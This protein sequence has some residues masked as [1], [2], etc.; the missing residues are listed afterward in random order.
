LTENPPKPTDLIY[1]NSF[2]HFQF[3]GCEV[4]VVFYD[5]YRLSVGYSQNDVKSPI[6]ETRF[7]L[8]VQTKT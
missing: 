4:S 1:F 6:N 3:H 7:G 2:L 8:F 5:K